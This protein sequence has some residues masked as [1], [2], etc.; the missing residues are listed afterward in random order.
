M[1]VWL[2]MSVDNAVRQLL[3]KGEDVLQRAVILFGPEMAAPGVN[4][5]GGDEDSEASLRMLP[6]RK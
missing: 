5:L 2:A 3:L 6:S 4:G 1:Y